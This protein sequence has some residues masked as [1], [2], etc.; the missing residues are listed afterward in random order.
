M[1]PTSIDGTDITGATIDGTDVTEITVDGDTVFT[2]VPPIPDSAVAHFDALSAFTESDEGTTITSWPDEISG[3]P[4][5]TGGNP[6]VVASGINGNRAVSFDGINDK[7]SISASNWTTISQ[8]VTTF[9]VVDSPVDQA[10]LMHIWGDRNV[11]N[12]E[13]HQ[14]WQGGPNQ[15]NNYAGQSFNGST[16]PSS[17]LLTTIWDG[18]NS[19]HRED[20]TQIA[21]GNPGPNS[22]EDFNIGSFGTVRFWDSEIG[23]ILLCDSRLSSTEI[24]EQEQRMANRWGITI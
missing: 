16:S 24:D 20:G 18:G 13:F 1:I 15:W 12:D 10:A 23:E 9:T 17:Q 21:T 7:L 4:D 5:A 3:N 11:G 19:V 6:T 22:L 14:L 8:P 2:A